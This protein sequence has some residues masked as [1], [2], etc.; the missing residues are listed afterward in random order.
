MGA[1]KHGQEAPLWKCCKVFLSINSYSKMPSK[2]IIYAL[3]SQT[4]VSF[5]SFFL[6]EAPSLDPAGGLSFPDR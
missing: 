1:R 4:V 2:Q 6:T 3:F 5:W